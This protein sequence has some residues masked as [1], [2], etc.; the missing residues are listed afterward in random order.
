MLEKFI[1]SILLRTKRQLRAGLF[2][3][4]VVLSTVL[5]IGNVE[6]VFAKTRNSPPVT[7]VNIPVLGPGALYIAK[8]DTSIGFWILNNIEVRRVGEILIIDPNAPTRLISLNLSQGVN[9]VF[10]A[11]DLPWSENLQLNLE[12]NLENTNCPDCTV[13]MPLP[14]DAWSDSLWESGKV[15]PVETSPGLMTLVDQQNE[16]FSITQKVKADAAAQEDIIKNMMTDDLTEFYNENKN[17]A[18]EVQERAVTM[19]K[20]TSSF[21]KTGFQQLSMDAPD[22]QQTADAYVNFLSSQAPK[23]GMASTCTKTDQF[24]TRETRLES[25][26]MLSSYPDPLPENYDTENSPPA[27]REDIITAAEQD[28]LQMQNAIE[29]CI[30]TLLGPLYTTGEDINV[31]NAVPNL[32]QENLISQE[33]YERIGNDLSAFVDRTDADLTAWQMSLEQRFENLDK[34][35]EYM[36]IERNMEKSTAPLLKFMNPALLN[37]NSSEI[38]PENNKKAN[39]KSRKNSNASELSSPLGQSNCGNDSVVNFNLFGVSV[40]IGTPSGDSI[41]AGNSKNLIITLGGDDCVQGGDDFDVVFTMQGDDKIYGGGGHN[42]LFGGNDVDTIYS[43]KGK[44]YTFPVGAGTL[45]LDLGSLISGGA[46]GD[47]LIGGEVGNDPLNI[48]GYTDVILGDGLA[49][50]NDAGGDT[51]DGKKGINLIFSQQKDDVVSTTGYGKISINGVPIIL[52]S[53][54]WTGPGEDI[55]TGTATPILGT[56]FG[57]VING[58]GDKDTIFADNGVD[59]IFANDGDDEVNGGNGNDIII[60]GDGDDTAHGDDGIDFIF[61]NDGIDKLFS[62]SGIFAIMAGNDGGDVITGGPG[63]DLALGNADIDKINTGGGFDIIA[64]GGGN[65]N[66]DGSQ[67]SDAILGGDGNDVIKTG[68]GAFNAVFAGDGVDFVTGGSGIDI[69]FGMSNTDEPDSLCAGGANIERLFGGANMDFIV[70]GAGCDELYGEGGINVLIGGPSPDTL[71]GGNSTDFMWGGGGRDF[72]TGNDGIDVGFGGDETDTMNGGTGIDVLSGGSQDDIVNGDA[73]SDILLGFTG[74]D[75]LNGNSD[76][77]LLI[78]GDGN[79]ILN[80]GTISSVMFGGGGNDVSNAV[81]GLNVHFGG[82]GSDTAN[83]GS[84]TDVMFGGDGGDTLRGF[85]GNDIIFGGEVGDT[86]DGGVGNNLNFGN[87]G[88]DTINNTGDLNSNVVS[89]GNGGGD[90][91]IASAGRV[92]AFGNSEADDLRGGCSPESPRD[93][94]FGNSGVDTLQGTASNSRDIV[95]GGFGSNNKSFC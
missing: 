54:F 74:N 64:G 83:G 26:L 86:L 13:T 78:G 51:I 33:A 23:I 44:S 49:S 32:S 5:A 66:L 85:G 39:S 20:E 81:N 65:D 53:V 37:A 92:V 17:A 69:I 25:D 40:L 18:K 47:T 10:Y 43:E 8:S 24:W 46:G 14:S 16:I 55:I 80:G 7:V 76:V 71:V 63:V 27:N 60:L 52:G 2:F 94:L 79:D 6:N 4:L 68:D 3:C 61:G 70:G 90:T 9:G 72:I 42:A 50:A 31:P 41:T 57:D 11:D 88:G 82:S 34:L 67:D 95:I 36:E 84:G 29:P 35:E 28:Y 15:T 22:V 73:G 77:N 59:F 75:S 12:G 91:I 21:E 30:T 62:D 87:G 38:K 93:F 58:G 19:F 45:T 48:F 89:F 1:K 56:T